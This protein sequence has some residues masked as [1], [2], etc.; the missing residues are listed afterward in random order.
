MIDKVQ[1]YEFFIQSDRVN[2]ESTLKTVSDSTLSTTSAASRI[3]AMASAVANQYNLAMNNNNAS[4]SIN[5]DAAP[6]FETSITS[7]MGAV[8]R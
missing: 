5:G 6:P 4:A 3:G 8:N 7:A 2:I 1:I